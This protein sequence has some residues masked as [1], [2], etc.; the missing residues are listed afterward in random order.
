[1]D[2]AIARIGTNGYLVGGQGFTGS[3]FSQMAE[4]DIATNQTNYENMLE[5]YFAIVEKGRPNFTDTV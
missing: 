4:F 5:Q 3:L 2:T 1:L